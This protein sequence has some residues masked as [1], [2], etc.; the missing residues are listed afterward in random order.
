MADRVVVVDVYTYPGQMKP[1]IQVGTTNE[2][3]P[4]TKDQ[5]VYKMYAAYV[6]DAD[7]ATLT[8]NISNAL[9]GTVFP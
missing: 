3:N 7:L 1:G 8:T 9:G 5:Q 6:D 2:Y 4:N